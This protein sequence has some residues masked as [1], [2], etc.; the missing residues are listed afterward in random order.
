[1]CLHFSSTL[2][3]GV[4]QGLRQYHARRK[5]GC[6]CCCNQDDTVQREGHLRRRRNQQAV[7][8]LGSLAWNRLL[9]EHALGRVCAPFLCICSLGW[10]MQCKGQ[11]PF[12]FTFLLY[13]FPWLP[14]S[15]SPVFTMRLKPCRC[16]RESR[17]EGVVLFSVSAPGL[18]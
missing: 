16:E 2:L 18:L 9:H 17:K 7:T 4:D 15:L 1:M 12:L 3:C 14:W 11:T 8:T 13:S 6:P 10:D 5:K